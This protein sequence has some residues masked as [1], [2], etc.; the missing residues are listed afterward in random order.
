MYITYLEIHHL[1]VYLL[2]YSHHH[3]LIVGYFIS[4]VTNSSHS[5]LSLFHSPWQL[6]I[7]FL[8]LQTS[9]CWTGHISGLIVCALLCL[10]SFA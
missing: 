8:S 5:Q 2:Y 6:F 10:A 4:P 3:K 1:K 9:L 7:S